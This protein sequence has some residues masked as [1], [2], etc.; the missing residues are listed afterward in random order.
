MAGLGMREAAKALGLKAYEYAA[1]E[2]GGYPIT[3]VIVNRVAALYDI[4]PA[5]VAADGPLPPPRSFAPLR[6]AED[7][8]AELALLYRE[9]LEKLYR[10]KEVTDPS[11][12]KDFWLPPLPFPYPTLR[13]GVVPTAITLELPH[14]IR[15]TT[16]IVRITPKGKGHPYI[17]SARHGPKS[18]T[19]KPG[20]YEIVA[21][22]E[23]AKLKI[24][25]VE[26]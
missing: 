18:V 22:T 17:R 14:E 15:I 21:L 19:L 25:V 13:V 9:V 3:E 4:P 8:A 24:R 10:I 6:Y 12:L 7:E 5:T 11:I 2:R 1:L 16:G 23:V 20:R 26:C